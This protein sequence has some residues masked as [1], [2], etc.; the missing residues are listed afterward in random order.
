MVGYCDAALW[1]GLVFM[2]AKKIN[3][4]LKAPSQ[5]KINDQIC[6]DYSFEVE[7]MGIAIIN[8]AI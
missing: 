5:S 1:R 4:D 6:I 2:R 8:G 3:T 7:I